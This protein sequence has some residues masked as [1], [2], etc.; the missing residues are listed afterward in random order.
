VGGGTR[1]RWKEYKMR[2]EKAHAR[3]VRL[4][5]MTFWE[6]IGEMIVGVLAS[7]AQSLTDLA[8]TI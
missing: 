2:A 8:I 5:Q 4:R 7:A 6:V 3:L 1:R